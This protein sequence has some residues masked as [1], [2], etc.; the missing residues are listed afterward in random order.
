MGIAEDLAEELAG[1]G[2]QQQLTEATGA[3]GEATDALRKPV[4]EEVDAAEEEIKKMWVWSLAK[5]SLTVVTA[6]GSRVKV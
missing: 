1:D 3:L 5:V 2:P 6:W 4:K